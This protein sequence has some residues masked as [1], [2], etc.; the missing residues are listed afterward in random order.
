MY[1]NILVPIDGSGTSNEALGEAVRLAQLT[2][3]R[4][5]LL[6]VVDLLEHLAGLET[7]SVHA[8]DLLP[9]LVQAGEE[10]LT[11]TAAGIDADGL[12][13]ETELFEGGGARVSESIVDRAQKWGA[14]L[15]VLGTHGRR[16]IGRV[17]MGSD[18]EQV[19]RIS[20]VPV[21]LVRHRS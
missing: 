2:G 16:G 13:I 11:R 5:R 15:I 21:L 3:G 4:I 7:A 20:P 9:A 8:R 1:T 17:M 14:D 12:S 19:V 18:A 10:L 6:H